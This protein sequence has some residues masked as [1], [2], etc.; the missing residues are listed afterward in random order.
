MLIGLGIL[1][2]WVCT[3]LGHDANSMSWLR[4]GPNISSFA[5]TQVTEKG[6]VYGSGRH[7]NGLSILSRL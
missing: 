4:N 7:C 6:K 5:Y 2:H 3:R 1:F